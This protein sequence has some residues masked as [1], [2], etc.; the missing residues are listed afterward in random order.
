M[1]GKSRRNIRAPVMLLRKTLVLNRLVTARA[2]HT[3]AT[4]EDLLR[5]G[6]SR[7]YLRVLL[8]R[9]LKD[10]LLEKQNGLYRATETLQVQLELGPL[11]RAPQKAGERLREHVV[12]LRPITDFLD[13]N[14]MWQEGQRVSFSVDSHTAE[15]MRTA[16]DP[17]TRRDRAQQYSASCAAFSLSVSRRN[18]CQMVIKEAGWMHV[19]SGWL[20]GCGLSITGAQ[21]VVNNVMLQMPDSIKRVEMPVLDRTVK[22]QNVEFAVKTRVGDDIIVSN[23]NYSTNIDWEIYGNA[24]LVDNMLAALGATQHNQVV[25]LV[26][27]EQKIEEL[28]KQIEEL[29]KERESKQNKKE[30]EGNYGS[31]I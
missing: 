8:T 15:A 26:A 19:F 17:P 12:Q 16:M 31:Y 22:A 14:A 25:A 29:R 28:T 24:H 5:T 2:N 11:P 9:L 10:G 13:V 30:D 23:I 7:P 20:V 4:R 21:S 6:I 3:W 18:V 1:V 27:L